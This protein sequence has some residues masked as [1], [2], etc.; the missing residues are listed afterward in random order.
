MADFTLSDEQSDRKLNRTHVRVDDGRGGLFYF[1][2]CRM[3]VCESL[4]R[5]PES[6][7]QRFSEAACFML[8]PDG[9][10]AAIRFSTILIKESK[11]SGRKW[12]LWSSIDFGL[13]FS[14]NLHRLPFLKFLLQ[15]H[16]DV[17]LGLL[18][19]LSY[20]RVPASSR[21]VWLWPPPHVIDCIIDRVKVAFT[22]V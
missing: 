12:H 7:I 22:N 10:E 2:G 15:S 11:K 9:L 14:S 16:N 18:C 4:T 21:P 5:D 6:P 17:F 20:F 13:H 19:L 3:S 8:R 1:A